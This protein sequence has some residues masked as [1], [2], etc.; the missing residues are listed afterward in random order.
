MARQHRPIVRSSKRL[1][2]WL[3]FQP[4]STT[5]STSATAAAIFSLNAVALALRP[6]TIVRTRFQLRL[7]TDQASSLETQA[8][9]VG[10]AVV[11]DEAVAVGVTAIPTP[12]T[13]A[14]S[15]LWFAHQYLY[16]EQSDKTGDIRRGTHAV[17]E[18]KAMR[19][20]ATGQDIVVVAEGAGVGAGMIIVIG[21]RILIKT[22]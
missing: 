16:G 21:G 5:L 4:V 3:Q 19:K 12:N 2:L 13:E 20:V 10:L 14:G 11:S 22:N 18:S 9:A 1:T 8:C 15:S 6:F 7:G 17:M